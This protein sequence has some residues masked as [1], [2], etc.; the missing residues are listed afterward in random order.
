MAL[1]L[2]I[3]KADGSVARTPLESQTT[4]VGAWPGGQVRIVDTATGKAPANLTAK[5]VGDSLVVDNLPDGKT[6]E[7][8]KFYTD[9]SPSAPCA[10]AIDPADGAQAVTI[11]QSTPPIATLGE[12]QALM[13]GPTSGAAGAA[14]AAAAASGVPTGAI[15]GGLALLGVAAAAGG[16][17]GGSSKSTDTTAP[18]APTI[19]TVAGDNAVNATEHA[20][21]VAVTGTAEAGSTVTVTWGAASK[22]ATADASGNW[23]VNFATGEVPADG[24]TTISATARDAAGNTSVAGTRAVTVDTAVPTAPA[25]DAVAGD[26]IVNAAERTAGVAVTGDAE[27]GSTV[28]VTWGA[29]SKTAT[30]D[31]SGNWSVNFATGEVPADGNTTISATARDAAGNTSVA[32]TRPVTI[33]TAAPTVQTAVAGADGS[34]SGTADA[35]STV[36]L[37]SATVTAGNDGAYSFAAGTLS[38]GAAT[39]TATDAAGNVS[40]GKS[41]TGAEVGTAAADTLVGTAAFIDGGA[42]ND[43]LV[44]GAGGSVRNYQFEYWNNPAVLYNADGDVV[45]FGAGAQGGWTIGNVTTQITS[46]PAPGITQHS[47]GEVGGMF[48]GMNLLGNALAYGT[49][50]DTGGGA[51]Y[52]WRTARNENAPGATLSQDVVTDQGAQYTLSMQVSDNDYGTSMGVYWGGQLLAQYDGLTDTWSGTAPV[53]VDI[54]GA[55]RKTWSWTVTGGNAGT[56]ALEL[57][58][59]SDI[60]QADGDADAMFVDRVTLDPL[61]AA[62]NGTIVGGAGSDLIFGQGGDDTLYG[63]A[64]G[65]T[66]ATAN[67][68]SD[69]FVY[70]MR[71]GNGADVIKDFEVGADKIVL[72]DALD[73][74]NTA[75]WQ[76][77]PADANPSTTDPVATTINADTNLSF[78]DFVQGTSPSQYLAVEDNGSG[79]VKLSFWGETNTG[80]ATALGSVVLEG[81]AFGAGVNQY[82]SVQDLFTAGVLVATMDGFHAGLVTPPV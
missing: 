15:L 22:T 13:Y 72:I 61:G 74:F 71:A 60:P 31:A 35:G 16:G 33:D 6:V 45:T 43:V 14:P 19:A 5:R 57:R 53:E 29:A 49:E 32:G 63:G 41:V 37:G 23:S 66:A 64:F 34:V 78:E 40:A 59:Y 52:Y 20:A 7:I 79:S 12:N 38:A 80:T 82:D 68:V 21:G 65:D 46:G 9:C 28:T 55:N 27:A 48:A 36:K 42:G 26:N 67:H 70:S 11:S 56:T 69:A 58:A 4:R 73:T 24:N 77:P 18:S 39:V 30:A 8:T 17:G 25:V 62:G 75:P 10:L 50:D 3:T 76:A 44:G 1:M 2:E 51:R 47:G 81:V 54:A